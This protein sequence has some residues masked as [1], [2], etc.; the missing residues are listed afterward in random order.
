MS[1]NLNLDIRFSPLNN[2][3]RSDIQMSLEDKI[4][5]HR[6]YALDTEM[7]VTKNGRHVICFK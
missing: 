1:F 5:W 6:F 4:L 7:I 3:T 2:L